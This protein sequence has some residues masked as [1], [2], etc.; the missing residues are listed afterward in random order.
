MKG[1]GSGRGNSHPPQLLWQASTG[2]WGQ[3]V[4]GARRWSYTGPGTGGGKGGAG[5]MAAAAFPASRSA[6]GAPSSGGAAG[7]AGR[8]RFGTGSASSAGGTSTGFLSPFAVDTA[9]AVAAAGGNEGGGGGGGGRVGGALAALPGA[10]LGWVQQGSGALIGLASYVSGTTIST[11][12]GFTSAVIGGPAGWGDDPEAAAG[13]AAAAGGGAGDGFAAAGVASPRYCWMLASVL[14]AAPAL[15]SL[16]IHNHALP[17]AAQGVG[18]LAAALLGNT[19]LTS[20][21][22]RGSTVGDAG[23]AALARVLSA[24][25]IGGGGGGG[26]A[27]AAAAAAAGMGGGN[28][29][30]QSLNL[31]KCQLHDEGGLHAGRLDSSLHGLSLQ[32]QYVHVLASSPWC[33]VRKLMPLFPAFDAPSNH[34]PGV[35]AVFGCLADNQALRT[36]DLSHNRVQVPYCRA[37]RAARWRAHQV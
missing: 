19:R 31:R 26:A 18:A 13:A 5:G 25:G 11:L 6:G 2:L 20:L 29:T 1:G 35:I 3:G 15:K 9:A 34:R 23:A 33:V 4:P 7:A 22:L 30:L 21:S 27:A 16:Y 12:Q 14:A 28:T 8:A 17:E 32:H 24:S 36:L 10:L 37:Q